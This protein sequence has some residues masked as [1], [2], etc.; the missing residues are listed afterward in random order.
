M[1]V[2]AQNG[3]R[4]AS[5][6]SI[7][8]EVQMTAPGLLH[9]FGSK[10]DLLLAVL[11]ER[12]RVDAERLAKLQREG[13]PFLE[14]L[15]RLVEFNQSRRE[16]VQLFSVLVGESLPAG[17]PAHEHVAR[18][19]SDRR[20]VSADAFRAEQEAGE[21]RADVDVDEVVELLFAVMDGLQIQWLLDPSIDMTARFRAYTSLLRETISAKPSEHAGWRRAFSRQRHPE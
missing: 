1:S 19:Y 21:I 16:V 3:S 5:L 13:Q 9:H 4:G 20:R 2:M 10:N 7:G 12:D 15:E 14:S 11:T 18:R 17:H 6:Q 8:A